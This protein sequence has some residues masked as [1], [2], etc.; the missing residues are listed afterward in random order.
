MTCDSWYNENMGP[1]GIDWI[2]EKIMAIRGR[3]LA[4]LIIIQRTNAKFLNCF[5]MAA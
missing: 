1:T 4:S 5:A 2:L 3:M